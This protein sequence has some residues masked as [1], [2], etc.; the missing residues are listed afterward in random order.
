MVIPDINIIVAYD[1]EKGIGKDSGIPWFSKKDL[2]Y[3][4]ETTIHTSVPDKKNVV[5]MGRKTFDSIPKNFRPLKKRYNIVLSKS[6]DKI[7][8][9]TVCN[10]YEEAIH[11]CYLLDT[12]ETIW[13][14]GGAQIYR[15]ALK[16][17]FR[18][19]KLY[20]TLMDGFYNCDTFFP[21]ITGIWKLI[22]S[23]NEHEKQGDSVLKFK[24][25]V[26]SFI[27]KH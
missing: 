27:H 16:S 26:Y 9:V 3:F 23:K 8:G 11:K 10:S 1:Q 21:D 14:I 2:R 6:V 7:D 17:H 5:I 25:I 4:A 13:V 19:N 12:V 20:I 24:Y 15:E 22:S 18:L